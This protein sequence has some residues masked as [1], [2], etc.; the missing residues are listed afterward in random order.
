MKYFIAVCHH[1][2][3][4]SLFTPHTFVPYNHHKAGLICIFMQSQIF[5]REFESISTDFYE[6]LNG[7]DK[8]LRHDRFPICLSLATPI[9]FTTS[10]Y[11]VSQVIPAVKV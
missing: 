3:V 6:L 7:S 2:R 9:A 10:F 4:I 1:Q 11:A 5:T 8:H